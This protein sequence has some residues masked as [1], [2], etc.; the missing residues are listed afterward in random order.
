[1]GMETT[2]VVLRGP[3][4]L[5]LEPV[6]LVLPDAP[7]VLVDVHYSGISTGTERLLWTGEM[8][9][10]PGMGYPL[11][12]GYET[13][14]RVMRAPRASGLAE[15]EFVFVPGAN[16]YGDVR[17]LF[18]GAAKCIAVEPQRLTRISPNHVEDG[19]LLALAATAHHA[20]C[21]SGLPDLVIGHGALGRLIARITVALGG[22]PIVWET[23]S[24]RS[25]GAAGYSVV[26]PAADARRDYRTIVDASGDTQILDRAML[27]LARQGEIVLAG[28][29]AEP[30]HFVFPPAFMREASI[31][32]AAQWQPAD[33]EAVHG[34]VTSGELALGDIITH[35][36]P[37]AEAKDA[38][39]TAFQDPDCLK[40]LLD[41]RSFQ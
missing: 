38:Y 10:F 12:P 15:G 30:L 6:L 16:C 37:A 9:A 5:S 8:P 40:M 31:R 24:A 19:T 22:A 23:N 11:V 2:A 7:H 33:L 36:A 18:G 14:G 41:W 34:L 39:D 26:A 20:V 4:Q 35:C 13:T 3:G 28:F 29:Y 1:M 17:G 25:E 32:I 27:H 21:L